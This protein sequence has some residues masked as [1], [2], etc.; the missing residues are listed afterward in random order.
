MTTKGQFR[1]CA[2]Y[3]DDTLIYLGK[4]NRSCSKWF[5]SLKQQTNQIGTYLRH[6]H[7]KNIKAKTLKYYIRSG[8]RD[9]AFKEYYYDLNPLIANGCFRY[10]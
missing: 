6:N 5:Y 4:A 1:I 3:K 8:A 9:K 10:D 2:L 7:D